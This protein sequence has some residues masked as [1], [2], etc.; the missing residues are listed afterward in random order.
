MCVGEMITSFLAAA[1][2]LGLVEIREMLAKTRT[3]VSPQS[4][5]SRYSSFGTLI[6]GSGELGMWTRPT[7]GPPL[8]SRLALSRG[9]LTIDSSQ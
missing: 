5:A 6:F 1:R 7:P 4:I 9:T 2:F 3:L 8:R